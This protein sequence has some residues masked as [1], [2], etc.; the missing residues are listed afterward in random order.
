MESAHK[1][2]YNRELHTLL[3]FSALINSSLKIE[4]VLNNAMK[5]AEEFMDAEASSIYELDETKDE[6]FIRLARGEKK[7]PVKGIRLK[8]GEGIAGW[9]VQSGEPM[10]VP[11]ASK[12]IKFSPKYDKITGF[13]T[14]SL[15]CVPLTLKG[16]IMGAIQVLNKRSQEPFNNA[17]LEILT[18]MSHQIAVAMENAKLYNR[19]EQKFELTA[20]ELKLAQDQLIR[21]ERLAAM[22]NLVN[23]VAHEIRNPIMV[24]GGFAQRIKNLYD[25]NIEIL[26]YSDIILTESARLERLVKKVKELADVQSAYLYPA[27]LIPVIDQVL[28]NF[29]PLADRQNVKILA[30]LEKDLPLINMDPSQI[31]IALSNILENALES[32]PDKGTLELGVKRKDDSGI[33]III[34]DTGS[35]IDPEELK[36]IYDPFVTS[37]TKGVG[38]GLTMVY[39]I[40]SNHHGEIKITSNDSEGTTVT[41]VLPLTHEKYGSSG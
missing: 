5:W 32:M 41:I 27:D 38:L 37:K 1:D 13:K 4:S 28:N 3:N 2:L 14:R 15:I 16:K 20:K 34:K 39:Q 7:D 9:V 26:N 36:S 33:I 17:D 24:I 6:L 31:G 22:G 35:G 18:I 11:D 10:V 40:I 29:R 21:T 23:G 8:V 30:S 12:E 19:L 25:G